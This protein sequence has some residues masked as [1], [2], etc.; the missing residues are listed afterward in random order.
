MFARLI[1]LG[2]NALMIRS[3]SDV[4]AFFAKH[5]EPLEGRMVDGQ[6]LR[7]QWIVSEEG[8]WVHAHSN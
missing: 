6:W 1:G 5:I 7:Y 8:L 3:R 4:D 2:H